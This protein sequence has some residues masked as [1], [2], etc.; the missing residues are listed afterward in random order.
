[1]ARLLLIDDCPDNS[2]L[3]GRVLEKYGHQIATAEE[4]LSGIEYARANTPDVILLDLLM[5]GIDG[6]ETC[7]RLKADPAT[8]PIPV[9]IVSAC[10]DEDKMVEAF[11]AGAHDYV[12]KPFMRTVVAAR[13]RAAARLSDANRELLRL[14]REDPLL[15]IGNRRAMEISLDHIHELSVRYGRPYSLLLFDVDHFKSYN[16]SYGH[17][18]GDVALQRLA[19]QVV[20][21]LRKSA[22]V[23]RYGGE[24]L[25]AMLP[26]T[27][28]QFAQQTAARILEDASGCWPWN[29]A[30]VGS[31][32]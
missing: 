23:Y 21:S 18:A 31:A 16:D 6:C 5:P 2:L 4:G 14:A 28:L 29:T 12:T 26:E 32:V 30:G 17:P 10:E 15:G 9:L 20:D 22:R 13:V 19:Q 11:D 24:E 8:A 25:L 1:M 3:L 7:R 27:E